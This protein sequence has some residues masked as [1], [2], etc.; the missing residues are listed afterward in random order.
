MKPL[1]LK[2]LEIQGFK[3]FADRVELAFNSGLTVIVGPNGS[4]K[5]NIADAIR[6]VLGEQ[7]VKNL[8]GSR[9]EDVIF[10]GSVKR[11]PV[12]M[13][14]VSLTL[15]NSNGR[16][17]LEFNEITVT[18]RVYRNGESE[19]LIN[20]TPCRLKDIHELFLDTGLG[21]DAYSIIGQGRVEEILNA[22][23]EDRRSIIEEAAGIVR[24]RM[25][26]LEAEK[27]LQETEADLVR[28]ED[29]ISELEGQLEPLARQ[30][31]VAEKYL[32]YQREE[33]E[34]EIGC[35]VR[36]GQQVREK[37][38][39]L[40]CQVQ[41][42]ETARE[43]A[44]AALARVEASRQKF[45]RELEPLEAELQAIQDKY[46]NLL[47][48][49]E[50]TQGQLQVLS[51]QKQGRQ[52]QATLLRRQLEEI[53][54]ELADSGE[55]A[56][57]DALLVQQLEGKRQQ[58][59]SELAAVNERAESLQKELD[60]I[61][62]ALV[63]QKDSSAQALNELTRLEQQQTAGA[64]RLAGLREK[65][66][67]LRN[68]IQEIDRAITTWQAREKQSQ[69]WQQELEQGRQE[70]ESR[71]VGLAQS[72]KEME[73]ELAQ[74]EEIFNQKQQQWQLL[75]SKAR[76]LA[77]MQQD[78]EGYQRA[79]RELLL[80][81]QRGEPACQEICGV[82]AELLQVPQE[83]EIAVEV[84]LGGALQ[85]LV[86]ETDQGAK[87]AI[88]YLKGH[89]LGRATFLPLNTVTASPLREEEKA[90]L[91]KRPGVIGVAA[92]LVS[93]AEKY[94]PVINNL[95]GRI[96]VCQDLDAALGLARATG[97]RYR[98]VTLAGDMLN[99][100]GSLT[101]GSYQRRNAN[102]LGR[103]RELEEINQAAKQ[104]NG[105]REELRKQIEKI[106]SS[107]R[108]NQKQ[109]EELETR[110]AELRLKLVEAQRDWQE[111]RSRCQELEEQREQLLQNL[112]S[113][114]RE[115]TQ[116]ERELESLARKAAELETVRQ[117][118]GNAIQAEN[119]RLAEQ[120]KALQNLIAH[121]TEL[122]VELAQ[123][124]QQLTGL[125]TIDVRQRLERRRRL[126]QLEQIQRDLA[127]LE[128]EGEA[129]EQRK[130]ELAERWA[131]L[132]QETERVREKLQE[133]R[134]K[135]QTLQIEERK[136][137]G[138]WQSSQERLQ[139][140]ERTAHQLELKRTRQ[141]A[142]WENITQRLWDDFG[143]VFNQEQVIA[144][145]GLDLKQAMRRIKELKALMAELG[146][147]NI[148]AIEEYQRIQE[149]YTFLQN[150]AQDLKEAKAALY[151]VIAEMEA[152]M[153]QRFAETFAQV[154][155][156]FSRVFTELFGGG[157][158][159]LQL[160]DPENLLTTGVDIIA[161]PPGKKTQQLSLLSGGE[162][163]L[164]AISL[165]FAI[166]EVRPSPFV[167]LDEIEA[168]LDEANVARF[169]E[170]VKNFSDRVQF[171]A[172]SHRKGTM[173]AADILYGVTM[174]DS[175]SSK[176]LAL[177]MTR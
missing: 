10:S 68:Q 55:T 145:Q 93:Y 56:A 71:Q 16:F 19:F 14:E 143:M 151:D 100:G 134:Q 30:A 67:H 46:T 29:I 74:L 24:Y 73:A 28:V 146:Q 35:L 23:P 154:A 171:L 166:L 96:I 159:R 160:T 72:R 108:E 21:R 157:Q 65:I 77:D 95:L 20:K 52:E 91:L 101:G 81:R 148:G 85:Y 7:S 8:R 155:E 89:N 90:T 104:V 5:S 131:K 140:L 13:A 167:V 40:Q 122:K 156:H 161:Q 31:E 4:G 163:A 79:V 152:I 39:E 125:K 103:A 47:S 177:E 136:L 82:V 109:K 124:E 172:V 138:L 36:Q 137:L 153:A 63:S 69:K 175:G 44:A 133:L 53:E 141:E 118:T 88:E 105:E 86:T 127:V 43:E 26:K 84:A 107:L 12:G 147:V 92:D 50:H 126:Q 97:F 174:D 38:A 70:H 128:Q 34:L 1:L 17:P 144:Y 54:T 150:Q 158:A 130:N 2:R 168:A 33:Q 80:R 112:E 115:Y 114:Q 116:V 66:E 22:R 162:K 142:E 132:Q 27:K 61:R 170:Y 117:E 41:E 25:R 37:L 135:R 60:T 59:Q 121:Q 76:V 98:I 64:I 139:E 94:R 11:K 62:Q 3:S 165:L 123:V 176:V 102:L 57:A 15:D 9:L 87:Q 48:E 78:Y 164:T 173:E 32:A 51:T 110:T 58:L 106:R 120:E 75:A 111:A 18:R 149:R 45:Q 83:Y 42:L 6:W 169:A 129:L 119:N 99:P 49:G 113:C